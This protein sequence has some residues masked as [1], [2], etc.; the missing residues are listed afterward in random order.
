MLDF[1]TYQQN[2]TTTAIYPQRG[3]GNFTYPALGLAG[4]T[5]EVCEK[6]KKAIRDDGGIITLDR[7]VML[8]KELG[9]VLWYLSALCTELGLSLEAVA[10]ENLE[11]LAARKK[12]GNIQGS[13]DLR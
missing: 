4:E 9:D 13:G 11:K 1:A 3:E 5:G 10:A 2:A 12:T 7:R 6:L 8:A